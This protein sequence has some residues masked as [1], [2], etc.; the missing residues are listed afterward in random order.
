MHKESSLWRLLRPD[1]ARHVLFPAVDVFLAGGIASCCYGLPAVPIHRAKTN[2]IIYKRNYSSLE[3]IRKSGAVA[4]ICTD[5][6]A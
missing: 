5:G 6:T 4:G 1:D 3:E 2:L